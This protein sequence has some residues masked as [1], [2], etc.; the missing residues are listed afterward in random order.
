MLTYDG[1]I[2]NMV[3]KFLNLVQ[4]PGS[5]HGAHDIVASLDDRT[6]D[7]SYLVNILQQLAI[8]VEEASIDKVVAEFRQ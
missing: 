8:S 4:C 7:V 2:V 1:E 5:V 3:G 6:R